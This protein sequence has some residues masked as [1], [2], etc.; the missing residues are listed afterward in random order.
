M[1]KIYTFSTN[2]SA[3]RVQILS[4]ACFI[5]SSYQNLRPI[6][7]GGLSLGRVV[8]YHAVAVRDLEAEFMELSLLFG[9]VE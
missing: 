6:F 7:D 5:M 9:N 3:K 1:F 2:I 8:L 4:E